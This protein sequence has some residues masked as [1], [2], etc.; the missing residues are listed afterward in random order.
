MR[1]EARL[2]GVWGLLVL[3]CACCD[4]VI[5]VGCDG[6]WKRVQKWC[7]EEVSKQKNGRKGSVVY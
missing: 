5:K 2:P 1:V 6:G 4:I 7:M 3:D